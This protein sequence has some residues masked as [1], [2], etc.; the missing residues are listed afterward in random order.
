MPNPEDTENEQNIGIALKSFTLS[1]TTVAGGTAVSARA[2]LTSLAPSGG[3]VVRLESS[4]PAIAPVPSPFVVQLPTAVRTFNIVPPVVSQPTPVTISATYGLVTISRTLTVVPPALETLS[5]TRSTMVGSCQ[6]ATARVTLTGAAPPSG[7]SV[8]LSS[9]TTGVHIPATITI[10]P[11]ARS[12]GLTFSAD[13]VH[14]RTTGVLTAA[15]GGTAKQLPLAVQADLP[16]GGDA[17]AVDGHRRHGVE[18]LGHDRMRRA[19]GWPER[20]ADEHDP[21]RRDAGG[22]I[23][24]VRSRLDE[25]GVPGA[26]QPGRC[27]HDAL[28]SRD[29]ECGDE[30]RAA[31]GETVAEAFYTDLQRAASTPV[32]ASMSMSATSSPC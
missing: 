32:A 28:H 3:A 14:A 17:D 5:L 7:A 21:V 13:A 27:R 9:T 8:A 18:R 6:T 2:E 29:R 1:E 23:A 26:H 12:A 15:F 4:D 16:H 19:S 24:I 10:A 25:R 20:N 22:R 31:H 11:G 30:E